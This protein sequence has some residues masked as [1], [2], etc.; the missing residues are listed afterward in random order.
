MENQPKSKLNWWVDLGLFLAAPVMICLVA[1]LNVSEEIMAPL[2]LFLPAPLALILGIRLARRIKAHPALVVLLGLF[3][4]GAIYFLLCI[5]SIFG[6]T[7][8]G[9]EMNIH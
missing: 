8:V 7:I 2:A 3:F 1:L 9:G 4:V 6:C 5:L